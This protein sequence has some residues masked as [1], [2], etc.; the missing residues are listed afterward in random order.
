MT[1][2]PRIR[3]ATA[4]ALASWAA[5]GSGVAGAE[6]VV[7]VP[8]RVHVTHNA[9]SFTACGEGRSL[10]A[11]NVWVLRVT[12]V[13]SAGLP[14]NETVVSFQPEFDECVVVPKAGA[15][16]GS[17]VVTLSFAGSGPDVSGTFGGYGVWAPG[18]ADQA[19]DTGIG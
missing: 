7:P 3:R 18:V 6:P 15:V 4:A 9:T 19:G 13:R 14:V 8:M 17:I 16:A 5:L 12:G 11:T 1:T 2:I 10:S